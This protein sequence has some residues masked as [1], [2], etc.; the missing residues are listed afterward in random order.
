[1][2]NLGMMFDD[3]KCEIGCI[4][5]KR[6]SVCRVKCLPSMAN[7]WTHKSTTQSIVMY[8]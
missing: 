2:T 6:A 4:I 5:P 8:S 3:T 7:L 1:L